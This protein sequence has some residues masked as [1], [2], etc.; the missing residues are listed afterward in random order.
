[1][2]KHDEMLCRRCG[3]PDDSNNAE[4]PCLACQIDQQAHESDLLLDMALDGDDSSEDRA[5]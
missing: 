1:M 4:G 3:K 5:R 2:P